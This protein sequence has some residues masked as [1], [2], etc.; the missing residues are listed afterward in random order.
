MAT[1]T[2][3][4]LLEVLL[5]GKYM[6]GSR[7]PILCFSLS[8]DPKTFKEAIETATREEHNESIVAANQDVWAL[9]EETVQ[10]EDSFGSAGKDVG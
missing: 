6:N 5:L 2:G 1:Y 4:N 8:H 10:V 3:M 9:H 7:D